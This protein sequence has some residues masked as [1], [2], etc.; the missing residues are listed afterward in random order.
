MAAKEKMNTKSTTRTSDAGSRFEPGLIAFAEK[1]VMSDGES[2]KNIIKLMT[3]RSSLVLAHR[4]Q[5]TISTGKAAVKSARSKKSHA[6]RSG[7]SQTRKTLR[8]LR[9][10]SQACERMLYEYDEAKRRVEQ[11][12]KIAEEAIRKKIATTFSALIS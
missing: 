12:G 1:L 4:L 5:N 6:A 2:E 9:E 7:K 8:A 10:Q 3:Q 11:S